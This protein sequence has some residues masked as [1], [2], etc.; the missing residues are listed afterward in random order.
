MLNKRGFLTSYLSAWARHRL[1]LG[2]YAIRSSPRA[3]AF[4]SAS[5][6]EFPQLSTEIVQRHRSKDHLRQ[7]GVY[8]R[9]LRCHHDPAVRQSLRAASHARRIHLDG[10]GFRTVRTPVSE[11][12]HQCWGVLF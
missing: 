5:L 11:S 8:R 3:E 1:T 6:K 4:F 12:V 2:G 9:G 7:L 10:P